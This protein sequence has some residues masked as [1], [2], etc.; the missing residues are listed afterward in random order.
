MFYIRPGRPEDAAAC[1]DIH[2]RSWI[3]A[4]SRCVPMDR[5]E[6]IHTGREAMWKKFLANKSAG[7]YVAVAEDRIIGI[8]TVNAAR[9]KD[10]P[11]NT[12][13]LIGLYLDP[14]YIGRGYGRRAMDWA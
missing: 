2:K 12:G 14:D 10:V 9:D 3:Y 13:E 1:A 6:Q 8:L 11:E 7:N 5:I 4:Y